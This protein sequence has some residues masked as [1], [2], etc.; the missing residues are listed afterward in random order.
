MAQA[1]TASAHILWH[2][3]I[4]EKLDVEA[5]VTYA[6]ESL[7]N[8]KV[9]VHGQSMGAQTAVLYAANVTPGTKGAADAVI[10]DSPVPGMELV[11]KEMFGDGDTK[12]FVAT[13]LTRTSRIFMK[14]VYGIDYDDG[15]TIEKASG[16]SIPTLIICSDKDEVCLP[17]QVSEVYGNIACKDKA[18]LHFD[19]AHIEGVIDDPEGYMDGV[20]KFLGNAGL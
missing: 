10:C 11:L 18:F 4:F 17:D 3:G 12:S 15:D 2:F 5:M 6:R 20:E 8:S 14:L 7:G 13:Y 19:S 16:I 1:E 9:I